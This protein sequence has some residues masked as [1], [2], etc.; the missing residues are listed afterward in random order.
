MAETNIPSPSYLQPNSHKHKE[1][2]AEKEKQKHEK[3]TSGK[4]T[5]RKKPVGK[6]FTDA[7]I[8]EDVQEVRSYLVWDVL[9]PALKDTIVDMIKKGAD[10]IFYGG[11]SA[12]SNI[13]RT[14]NGSRASYAGYYDK[15]NNRPTRSYN[16]RAVH[17]F[18]EVLFEDRKDAEIVL[19]N[20]V[21]QTMEYGMVSVAEFYE[22]AGYPSE[23]TDNKYGWPELGDARIVRVRDGYILDLPKPEPID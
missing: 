8:G 9:V 12:P 2:M 20:L 1:A 18:D 14:P 10:A 22:F 6:K 4:V 3:V 19:S 11:T 17:D 16:R 15:R 13:K 7:M 5:Q 23:F 21:E